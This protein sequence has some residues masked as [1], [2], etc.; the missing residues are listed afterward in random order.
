MQIYIAHL[1][2]VKELAFDPPHN[3][4]SKK[5]FRAKWKREE[6]MEDEHGLVSREGALIS[7][8]GL[9][10]KPWKLRHFSNFGLSDKQ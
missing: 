5:V 2:T 4:V 10:Q 6:M 7:R 9:E 1:K 8:I 3:V